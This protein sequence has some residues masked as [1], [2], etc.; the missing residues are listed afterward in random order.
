MLI[1]LIWVAQQ[2]VNLE[3]LRRHTIRMSGPTSSETPS[4]VLVKGGF[5]DGT[6]SRWTLS[7]IWMTISF[8]LS[9]GKR[10]CFIAHFHPMQVSLVVVGHTTLHI[11]IF[12]HS[13]G[14]LEI[15]AN[16]GNNDDTSNT[17][18]NVMWQIFRENTST[19]SIIPQLTSVDEQWLQ[20][21][22]AQSMD[23]VFNDTQS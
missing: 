18:D 5:Y 20:Q 15:Y 3:P 17:L 23:D 16:S 6:F 4:Q 9:V 8:R 12:L 7:M 14:L 21:R 13:A 2:T 22:L 10:T 11:F 1:L 19:N